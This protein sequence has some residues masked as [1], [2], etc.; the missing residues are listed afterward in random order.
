[1]RCW[2]ILLMAL[3][4]AGCSS[5]RAPPPNPRLADSIVVVANLNEQL[6]A[7]RGTPY[8]YGGMS[9]RGIDCSGF[10]LMTYRDKFALK[11]PRETRQLANVG[12]KIDKDDLLPGDLVFFKTGSGES[13]LHVG[14][15][16]TGNTFIHASTSR[17]VMR[18][19]LDNVYWRKNFWQARRI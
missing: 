11:V 3:F 19:S 8:R 14:I 6:H 5:H 4:L 18:S 12:A 15:Y 17:G 10:V 13:G 9:R 1:M 16:D 7:W 2:F